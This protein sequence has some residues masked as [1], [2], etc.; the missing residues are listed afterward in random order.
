MLQGTTR[1]ELK[2]LHNIIATTYS[3]SP[4]MD[5]QDSCRSHIHWHRAWTQTR[6]AC[7]KLAD[8]T[9]AHVRLVDRSESPRQ[10]RGTRTL[11]SQYYPSG[12]HVHSARRRADVCSEQEVPPL[13]YLHQCHHPRVQIHHLNLTNCL[14]NSKHTVLREIVQ[15]SL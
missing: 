3:T 13:P 11:D 15:L 12:S 14:L 5:R 10:H 7:D 4:R 1:A 6:S 9:G 8:T 2:T